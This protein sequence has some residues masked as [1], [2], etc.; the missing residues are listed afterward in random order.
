MK[1]IKNGLPAESGTENTTEPVD[2]GRRQALAR[3][4]LTAAIAYAAPALLPLRRAAAE[5]GHG[6]GDN[7]GHGNGGSGGND[8][9]GGGTGP[10]GNDDDGSGNGGNGGSDGQDNN[11]NPTNPSEATS[12][13]E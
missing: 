2:A 8:N 7:S 3:L 6:G 13:S 10:S 1:K 12:P 4:G 5:S 11:S 9:S